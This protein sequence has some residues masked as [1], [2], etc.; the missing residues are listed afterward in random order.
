MNG[1]ACD[2]FRWLIF[3]PAQIYKWFNT[4]LIHSPSLSLTHLCYF[5]I[6][7]PEF[8]SLF[9]PPLSVWGLFYLA[10]TDVSFPLCEQTWHN[11]P[12]PPHDHKTA[13]IS[14]NHSGVGCSQ[15][16]VRVPVVKDSIK[17]RSTWPN[18]FNLSREGGNQDSPRSQGSQMKKSA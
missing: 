6:Y 5:L 17:G 11:T 13:P 8:L 7:F 1:R 3:Q 4:A 14:V 2:V 9:S 12:P 10:W 18:R 15:L 16:A